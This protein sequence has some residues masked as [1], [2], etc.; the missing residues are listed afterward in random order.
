MA[1]EE[2]YD[3]DD[4]DDDEDEDEDDE[5]VDFDGN[6]RENDDEEEEEEEEEEEDAGGRD[7][8][9]GDSDPSSSLSG[10][11]STICISK[12]KTSRDDETSSLLV[13]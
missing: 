5:K 9:L 12:E 13:K 1:E 3:V 10:V 4:D 6:G 8:P 7:F 2:E 11:A